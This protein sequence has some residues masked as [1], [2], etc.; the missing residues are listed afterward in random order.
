MSKQQ[1]ES[2]GAGAG[3]IFWL[4]VI[5]IWLFVTYPWLLIFPLV[6]VVL[7]IMGHHQEKALRRAPRQSVTPTVAPRPVAPAPRP[8]VAPSA[9]GV[10]LATTPLQWTPAPPRKKPEP[11][12]PPKAPPRPLK[13]PSPDFIP[14]DREYNKYLARTWDE[15]FEEL[16]RKREQL[17]P[18]PEQQ[19]P[20][21]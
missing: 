1:D 6:F 8:S 11:V 9:P 21:S 15:E 20:P 7:I 16:A 17:P 18:P 14:K 10:P 5:L 13:A 12:P 19:Y 3:C 4:V 2:Q